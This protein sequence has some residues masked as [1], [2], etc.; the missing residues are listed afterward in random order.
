M[1]SKR[2]RGAQKKSKKLQALEQQQKEAASKLDV[3]PIVPSFTVVNR[4]LQPIV[5]AKHTTTE[6][7]LEDHDK[8][9]ED[10]D[11]EDDNDLILIPR[12]VEVCARFAQK[13][14]WTKDD[15]ASNATFS[16]SIPSFHESTN[17]SGAQHVVYAVVLET[18]HHTF[19]VKKR[20][21]EF[22]AFSSALQ[23]KDIVWELP[24]KTWFRLT[25]E[26]A[27][28]DRRE[29]LESACVNLFLQRPHLA[30]DPLVRDFFQLD[31][32]ALSVAPPL[33]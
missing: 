17:E 23:L 5:K 26:S 25:Q 15:I 2:A 18:P 30:L 10:D 9:D 20:Y 22:D 3:T 7:P 6:Q 1:S 27:L 21:S 24:P 14:T 33:P 19:T 4:T 29:R 11:D 16:L 8:T 28:S 31:L 32:F 12:P 13:S